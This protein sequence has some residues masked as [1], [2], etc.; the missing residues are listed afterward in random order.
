MSARWLLIPAALLVIG[1]TGCG[2]KP[3]TTPPTQK[4]AKGET[5]QTTAS[6]KLPLVRYYALPG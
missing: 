3:P 2:E 5:S 4:A 6:K 1:V